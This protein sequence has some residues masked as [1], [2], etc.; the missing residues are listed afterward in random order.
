LSNPSIVVLETHPEVRKAVTRSYSDGRVLSLDAVSDKIVEKMMTCKG[1]FVY[2]ELKKQKEEGAKVSFKCWEKNG[3]EV[4]L[5]CFGGF[6]V[7][8]MFVLSVAKLVDKTIIP[9]DWREELDNGVAFPI[10]N[11]CT[12]V[13]KEGCSADKKENEHMGVIFEEEIIYFLA[14]WESAEDVVAEEEEAGAG[15]EDDKA[16]I[17]VCEFCAETPCFW[18]TERENVIATVNANH[19]DGTSVSKSSRRKSG[20]RYIWRVRNGVGQKGCRTRHPECGPESGI[21]TLFPDNVFMGFKEEQ[22]PAR[23]EII[24]HEPMQQTK[25]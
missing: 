22:R 5:T 6:L 8:K 19:G 3:L 1:P 20:F 4:N 2:E 10:V 25:K 12:L 7:G 13:M 15:T 17:L 21:R 18:S 16:D 24:I 11:T 14:K 9:D 23:S